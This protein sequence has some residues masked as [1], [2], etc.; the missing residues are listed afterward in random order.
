[1]IER[2]VAAG[3]MPLA[4]VQR[5]P[6]DTSGPIEAPSLTVERRTGKVLFSLANRI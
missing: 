1:M 2:N 4:F 3:S 5:V 6:S